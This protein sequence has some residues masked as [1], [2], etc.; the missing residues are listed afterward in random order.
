MSN[1]LAARVPPTGL[2]IPYC[3]GSGVITAV[4][5]FSQMSSGITSL[6]AVSA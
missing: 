2:T 3:H 4:G 5:L 1:R 6:D